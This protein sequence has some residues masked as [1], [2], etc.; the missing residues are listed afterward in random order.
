[1]A[2]TSE[3]SKMVGMMLKTMALRTVAMPRDPRSIVF[4]KAPV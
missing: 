2:V 3:S 4:D 1:M